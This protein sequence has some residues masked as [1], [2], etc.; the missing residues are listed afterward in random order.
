MR[1]VEDCFGARVFLGDRVIYGSNGGL[2]IGVVA[3]WNP[4]TI[5]IKLIKKPYKDHPGYVNIPYGYYSQLVK[6]NAVLELD[7]DILTDEEKDRVAKD[8]LM[9]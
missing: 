1:K 5:K 7:Y 9:R 6:I 2:R 8:E 3:K 4:E